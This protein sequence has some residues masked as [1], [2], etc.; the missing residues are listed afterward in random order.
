ILPGVFGK[1]AKHQ[2]YMAGETGSDPDSPTSKST[3]TA[4]KS[5]PTAPKADPRPPVSKPASSKQP[6][7]KPVSPKTQGKKR[8]LVSEISGRPSQA[9]KSKSG[10]VTKRRKPTSSLRSVDESVAE[11]ILEKEP[12]V[13]DEEADVARDLLTLQAPKKKSH[14]DRYIFQR[15]TS[16]PTGSSSHDESS[17]LYAELGLTDSDKASDEDVPRTDVGVQSEG[18]AGPNPVAQDEGQAG[19]NP[20]EQAEG[21]A[22]PNTGDAEAS[23]PLPSPIVHVGSD[24]KHMDLDVAEKPIMTKQLQKLKPNNGV[25]HDP[26]RYIFNPSNDNTDN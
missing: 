24:L 17:S 7:P 10:L 20:D 25:C 22:R 15:R 19:S 26:T 13:D 2:R 18:Q 8:K 1:V 3:K 4:K 12:R 16:T 23:Q 14:A 9:R 5:K 6:E 11:D 21:H